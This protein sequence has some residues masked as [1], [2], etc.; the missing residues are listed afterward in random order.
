MYELFLRALDGD[1][2][3]A[4]RLVS[5]LEK[6]DYAELVPL[7]RDLLDVLVL[8]QGED[9]FF[10]GLSGTQLA[11]F[12]GE[13]ARM[14]QHLSRVAGEKNAAD[15]KIGGMRIFKLPLFQAMAETPPI[16]GLAAGEPLGALAMLGQ[17]A[18]MADAFAAVA[19][20]IPD[21]TL[22]LL[23]G[24]FLQQ[25]GRLPEAEAAF[26]RAL[27]SPS[28][29]NHRRAA[30]FH[31]V[32][33]QWQLASS[34]KTPA[35][36]RAA[37]KE[38]AL[39]NLRDLAFV[40]KQPLPPGPTT[41]LVNVASGCGDPALGLALTEAALRQNPKD[42]PLLGGKLLL[43]VEL[44]A[45]D[46]AET[47]ARAITAL[48]PTRAAQAPSGFDDLLNLARAYHK[49]GRRSDALRWCDQ[50]RQQLTQAGADDADLLNAWSR[51]GVVYWQMKQLDQ[52]IP[53]FERIHAARQKSLGD[54]H[55]TTLLARAN[56][57]V[58]YRDAGRLKDAIALLE[59][60]D[61]AGRADG[62]LRWVRGELLTAYV[63]ARMA[64]EGTK[65]AKELLA[66]ARKEH[67][68]DRAA[69]AGALVQGGYAL[70]QL[71]AW[72]EAEPAL[73]EALSLR[74]KS[75]PEAW[76]TFNSRSLLG[77][78]LAGQKKYTEARPLLVQGFD[79]LKARAAQIPE[80]LRALRLGEAADRLVRLCEAQGM[81]EEAAKWRKEA[82][83]VR[84]P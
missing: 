6:T 12:G 71:Q 2:P 38:K 9:F 18:K 69:L 68:S 1:R 74:E 76:T 8:A 62:S 58:N 29:A 24:L 35:Q 11:R 66:E 39:A 48:L 53:I 83:A 26:R 45:L 56:L 52:S 50:V 70:V 21:G 41:A 15:A 13:Y 51:L 80:P 14:A 82:E 54:R 17:P 57:G 7:F 27:E 31:L 4:E 5:P 36:E 67:V 63:A 61:R 78:A 59:K 33:A 77:E 32:L 34:P 47:T 19:R 20:A 60:V 3:G 46:R 28:W 79:G 23:H 73:R 65:L 25:A 55:P 72:D 43:E 10:G 16:K 40:A 64:P 44:P 84:K 37:W 75:E 42:L 22:L 81:P 49:A 30:W